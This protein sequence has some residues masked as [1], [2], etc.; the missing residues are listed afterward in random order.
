MKKTVKTKEFSLSIS[1]P[2][3]EELHSY[4]EEQIL[5]TRG[6]MQ[7][8]EE[9]RKVLFSTIDRMSDNEKVL[10]ALRFFS[11]VFR[12]PSEYLKGKALELSAYDSQF[13]AFPNIIPV[14]EQ[15]ILF[16]LEEAPDQVE[17]LIQTFNRCMSDE[18]IGRGIIA[19]QID[20]YQGQLK[21]YVP[22]LK[23][24]ERLLGH[25]QIGN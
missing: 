13:S 22:M 25:E 11:L 15:K 1:E 14:A 23:Q 19:E 24:I 8:L 2:M 4:Y 9:F 17:L 20:S 7:G 18:R 10:S 6:I 3:L 16:D 21:D 12:Y 5:S